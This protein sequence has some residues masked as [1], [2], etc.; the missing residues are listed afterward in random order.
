MNK[1]S[2]E[3]GIT[4]QDADVHK[5]GRPMFLIQCKSSHQHIRSS[6]F[7]SFLTL[8]K[9]KRKLG[10]DFILAFYFQKA[11]LNRCTLTSVLTRL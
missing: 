6:R 3:A 10:G 1:S 7:K 2:G 11:V 9:K 5:G 4:K 8:T